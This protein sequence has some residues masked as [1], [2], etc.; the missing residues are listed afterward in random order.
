M[1][2]DP[3]IAELQAIYPTCEIVETTEAKGASARYFRYFEMR[4]RSSRMNATY[5]YRHARPGYEHLQNDHSPLE[6]IASRI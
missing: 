5:F 2:D 4:E 6:E 1:Q 3:I